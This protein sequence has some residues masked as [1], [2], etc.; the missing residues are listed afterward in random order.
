MENNFTHLNKIQLR[1]IVGLA[2]ETPVGEKDS[3]VRISVATNYI[4]R[5]KDGTPCIETTWFNVSA[6][7]NTL[8]AG[9]TLPGKGSAVEVEGRIRVRRITDLEGSERRTFEVVARKID[10]LETERMSPENYE[11]V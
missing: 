6:L 2:T 10:I 4:Y 7:R 5:M 9:F 3:V 11:N 1:G 8:P